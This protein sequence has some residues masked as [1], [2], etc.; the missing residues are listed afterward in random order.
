MSTE[1]NTSANSIRYS[2][3]VSILTIFLLI[4]TIKLPLLD[5]PL[6]RDEGEYAYIAW[7]LDFNEL[8][9]RDWFNQKPPAVFWVYRAAL[10]FPLDPISSIHLMAMLFTMAS[11]I[12][13]YFLIRYMLGRA[14]AFFCAAIFGVL[15]VDPLIQ[16]TAANTEVFMLFPIILSH[17]VFLRVAREEDWSFYL[18]FSVGALVG[19]AAAFKQVAA[20]NWFFFP[21]IYPLLRPKGKQ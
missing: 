7:R 19:I 11:A 14:E 18:P 15:S 4:L 13:L 12:V 5:I 9:Y 6:E 16:G 17:L 2:D 1:S 8:P 10:V 20:V 21:L 3:I